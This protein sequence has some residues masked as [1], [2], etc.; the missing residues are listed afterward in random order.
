MTHKNTKFFILVFVVAILNLAGCATQIRKP[1]PICPG[2]QSASTSLYLLQVYA[3]ATKN[4]RASGQ[5]L[6]EFA[7]DGKTHRE[8][9]PVKIWYSV[10]SRIRIHGDIAFNPRG[11]DVG[12]NEDEFWMAM[13]PKEAG[14]SYFWGKWAENAD[15]G[16]LKFGPQMFIESFGLIEVNQ[17]DNW[18]LSNNGG[19]DILSKYDDNGRIIK[20]IYI[21]NCDYRV[22]KIEYFD[23]NQKVVA[24]VELDDYRDICNGVL[25]PQKIHIFNFNNDGT[26]DSFR[27]KL[28]SIKAMTECYPGKQQKILFSR[29]EPRGFE[30]IYKISGGEIVEEKVEN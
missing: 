16:G 30:H 4:L 13:K 8:N 17:S 15:F 24:A 14:N 2:K 3:D 28:N 6:A 7:V 18:A 23:D 12:S 9:F 26:K 27:I 21:Y 19:T 1:M 10:P 11:L 5:C 20:K 22:R 25:V 29:P